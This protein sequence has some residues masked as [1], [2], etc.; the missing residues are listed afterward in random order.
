MSSTLREAWLSRVMKRKDVGARRH[1][2]SALPNPMP[3]HHPHAVVSGNLV[4]V[5]GLVAENR[6]GV[7]RG[8]HIDQDGTTVHDVSEQLKSI[9][10]QLDTILGEL[11]M[12]IENVV[13]ATFFFKNIDQYFKDFNETYGLLLGK[14]LPARTSIGVSAFPSDVCLEAK[15]V[16]MR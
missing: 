9:V 4:F 8:T 7:R 3:Y 2:S 15:F 12:G 6:D 14:V 13:D 16:A 10:A 11:G 5:S 1:I